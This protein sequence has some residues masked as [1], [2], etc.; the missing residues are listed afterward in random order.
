[1]VM[2]T[3]R[4]LLVLLLSIVRQ[5]LERTV[6]IFQEPSR[7]AQNPE[8]LEAALLHLDTPWRFQSI[9]APNRPLRIPD[10]ILDYYGWVFCQGGFINLQIT[11]EQFLTVAAAFKPSGIRPE[12]D[13]SEPVQTS[14]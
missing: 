7:A 2:K 10:E 5:G 1:M 13:E 6:E 14:D 11:F 9:S 12:Y 8:A 3:T 4:E